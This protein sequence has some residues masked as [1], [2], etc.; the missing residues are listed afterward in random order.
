MESTTLCK[1]RC[2]VL[3]RRTQPAAATMRGPQGLQPGSPGLW[4]YNLTTAVALCDLLEGSFEFV[5]A[6]ISAV[7]LANAW[8]GLMWL[9]G[10]WP[11]SHL[12]KSLPTPT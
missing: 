5:S 10:L 2:V 4:K 11:G 1:L 12:L 8:P 7:G 6:K 3:P 9:H